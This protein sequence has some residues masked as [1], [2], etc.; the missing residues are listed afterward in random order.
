[1]CPKPAIRKPRP[2]TSFGGEASL[3]RFSSEIYKECGLATVSSQ[4]QDSER[5]VLKQDNG[6]IDV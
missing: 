3:G 1:M 4:A 5:I 2:G 6:F